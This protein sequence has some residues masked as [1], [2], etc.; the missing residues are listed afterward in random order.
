MIT[1]SENPLVIAPD[2]GMVLTNGETY[3]TDSKYITLGVNDSTDN[4]YEITVEEAEKRQI[5]EIDEE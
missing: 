4:W 2:V 5:E 3:S 1:I